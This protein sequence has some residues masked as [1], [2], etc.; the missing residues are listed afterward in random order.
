LSIA[1]IVLTI[2]S[3]LDGLFRLMGTALALPER[4]GYTCE[5]AAD[6]G[7]CREI[8]SGKFII[9]SLLLINLALEESVIARV[10]K[11]FRLNGGHFNQL[12]RAPLSV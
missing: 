2:P 3:E 12:A 1:R 7:N 10:A 8:A 5:F 4:Q 11:P 9:W 6:A